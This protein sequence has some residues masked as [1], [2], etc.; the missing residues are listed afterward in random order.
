MNQAN[1]QG[2]P[3]DLRTTREALRKA[4]QQLQEVRTQQRRAETELAALAQRSVA[5]SDPIWRQASAAREQAQ[6]QA[7][8]QRAA[9][10]QLRTAI[11][12]GIA[13]AKQRPHDVMAA[14]GAGDNTPFLLMPVRVETRFVRDHPQGASPYELWVRVY[15]DA[16]AVDSHEPALT[17]EE[18]ADGQAFWR[19]IWAA[20]ATAEQA[21]W[22]RLVAVYPPPRAAWIVQQTTPINQSA[23]QPGDPVFPTPPG[24][25]DA[26]SQPPVTRVL[27]D[28]WTFLTYRGDQLVDQIEGNPIPDPLVAGPN[29]DPAEASRSLLDEEAAWMVN[30]AEAVAVGMAVRIPFADQTAFNRGFDR[31]VVLGVKDAGLTPD[32]G[33]SLLAELIEAHRFT[34]TFAVVPQGTPTNNTSNGRSGYSAI[35]EDSDASLN[36][37]RGAPQY[38]ISGD[39][40]EAADGQRLAESLGLAPTALERVARTDGQEEQNA[41]A[42]ATLLWPVTW[43]YYLTHMAGQPLDPALIKEARDHAIH[44][45]RGR[46]PLPAVRVGNTPYGIL[47]CATFDYW[48]SSDPFEQTLFELLHRLLPEWTQSAQQTPHVQPNVDPERVIV[49]TLGMQPSSS[50]YG[51]RKATSVNVFA[52]LMALQRNPQRANLLQ[53][54]RDLTAQP[55]Q[56]LGFGEFDGRAPFSVLVHDAYRHH[57]RHPLIQAEPLSESAGLTNNYLRP[58]LEMMERQWDGLNTLQDPKFAEELAPERPLLCQLAIHAALRAIVDAAYAIAERQGLGIEAVE[59]EFV[60]IQQQQT[61]LTPWELLAEPGFNLPDGAATLGDLLAQPALPDLPELR[62]LIEFKSALDWLSKLPSAEL[63]R[64]LTETLD[65]ASHR[66]D[67]WFTS[68]ASKRLWALRNDAGV[69]G[70]RLGGYGWLE[71]LRPSAPPAPA[72]PAEIIDGH[73][74]PPGPVTVDPYNEGYMLAP[75]INHATAAA[76]MRNGYRGR[77]IGGAADHLAVNLSSRRVRRALYLID[78]IR[79][80]QSLAAL[81]GYRFERGLHEEHPGLELDRFIH[82]L[83]RL[84]PLETSGMA[85]DADQEPPRNVVDG[86]RLMHHWQARTIPFGQHGLPRPNAIPGST[87]QREYAAIVAELNHLIDDVDSL[88]DVGLAESVYQLVN[89]NSTRAGAILNALAGDG[90]P[91]DP[92]VVRIPPAGATVTHRAMLLLTSPV[93]TVLGWSYGTLRGLAEPVLNRWLGRML[94]DPKRI[95]C[96]VEVALPGQPPA[97]TITLT[98]GD[99]GLAPLDFVYLSGV[100]GAAGATELEQRIRYHVLRQQPPGATAT[101][102]FDRHMSWTP[103]VL[104][105]DEI[106]ELARQLRDLITRARPLEPADFA[107]QESGGHALI[108]LPELAGRAN[109]VCNAF[110]NV[111]TILR[112]ALDRRAVVDLQN[113]LY[114]AASAG[115]QG[116][117]PPL[118]DAQDE[119]QVDALVAQAE[120]VL[121]ETEQR[122]ALARGHLDQAQQALAQLPAEG[123]ARET[124]STQTFAL[125]RDA[126]HAIFGESFQVLPKFRPPQ[127]ATVSATFNNQSALLA[128]DVDAPLRWFQQAAR[129]NPVLDR[130]ESVM[131]LAETLGGPLVQMRVGQLPGAPGQR[132]VGLPKAPNSEY[133]QGLLSLVAH[134]PFGYDGNAAYAGLILGYFQ[135]RIPAEQ[136]TT[137]VACH[138]DQPGARPPQ[139]LLLAVPP[140]VQQPWQWDDLVRTVN[141]TLD[142]A[143][144]RAVDLDAL[145]HVGHHLPALVMAVNHE[146]A[147]VSTDLVRMLNTEEK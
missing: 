50:D 39:V 97:Q 84:Y 125:L 64:L 85:Y 96:R 133:P 137:A 6:R 22:A 8:Q 59:P 58:I 4:E 130:C 24:K 140:S 11:R 121:A 26:W 118:V 62:P 10:R 73:L 57:W 75:S 31:L 71:Q 123:E 46:G 81:L 17:D 95:R 61:T 72:P 3:G 51:V 126:V 82:I 134:T 47:P 2:R 27:P 119:T 45:V 12:D 105:V 100:E 76:V 34:N 87:E 138:Y 141:N 111:N 131:L 53:A 18:V 70:I 122:Y 15:P 40:Q 129:I 1:A 74:L 67:A 103:A 14:P 25:P 128:G 65:T 20:P 9:I 147:T 88:A 107:S 66:L 16:I 120:S 94:G 77:S 114:V 115:V 60:G 35:E 69:T 78:G 108:D 68:L 143:R 13:A 41:R 21:A 23:Q 117:F 5:E 32:D 86:L 49:E 37:L 38:P 102:L 28:R 55:W 110:N 139:S 112:S 113:G 144:V 54:Q 36:L 79:A 106:G 91:A 90:V 124:A 89:G 19:E 43:G 109:Q 44:W 146:E 33:A 104:T 48:E 127:P 80:G 98:M 52:A 101:I 136:Q 92:E 132:W 145:N 29:P 63:E 30:F 56:E 7:D 135:E 93:P 42:M 83:R 99:L 142:L 116:A